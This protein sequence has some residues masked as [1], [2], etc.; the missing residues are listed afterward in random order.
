MIQ[1]PAFTVEPWS[2]RETALHVDVLAQTESVSASPR[3]SRHRW[4]PN[5]MAPSNAG[6]VGASHPTE[7]VAV[8]AGMDH[9]VDGPD[10]HVTSEAHADA[11]RVTVTASLTPGDRLQVTQQVAFGWSAIRSLPA[12]RDQVAAAIE[13]ADQTTWD[14]LLSEQR[15]Y[16][17]DFWARADVEVDGDA[18]IQQAVRFALFQVLQTGGRAEGRTIGNRR[19]AHRARMQRFCG[20]ESGDHTRCCLVS[21]LR[22]VSAMGWS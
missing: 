1:H 8:A 2:L 5:N 14:G 16:L 13:A 7:R 22:A 15:V 11:A 6:G 18:E 21:H 4:S 19:V 9:L 20:A 12:M 10:V 3:C 17:D